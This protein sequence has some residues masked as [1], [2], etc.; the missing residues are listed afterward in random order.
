MEGGRLNAGSG[1]HEGER[2][3]TL[4]RQPV[5]RQARSMEAWPG[6]DDGGDMPAGIHPATLEAVVAHFGSGTP[7][8]QRVARRLE[9]IYA[10][11]KASGHLAR[12]IVFGSFVTA[13]PAPNDVPND[14]DI[15]MLME[16][17][18]DVSQVS[19]DVKII[20]DHTAAHNFLGASVF[21]I[22]RAAALGGEGAAVEHWQITRSGRRRGIVE[23]VAH[24]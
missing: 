16:D 17:D 5:G 3:F 23:V 9:H 14:V 11:A 15:F 4:A 21:W 18:F 1:W 13:K 7:Q 8:R 20:F 2:K 24:G 12:F 22:R 10:L 19:N 6:F